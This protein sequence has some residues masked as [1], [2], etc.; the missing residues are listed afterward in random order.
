M[1]EK[2]VLICGS[3][4]SGMTLA[5]W[6]TRYGYKPKIIEKAAGLRKGGYMIDFWG[7]GYDTAEKMDILEELEKA[8]YNIP[9]LLY[10]DEDDEKVGHL[11]IQKLRKRL[12]YRH[13]NLLRSDLERILHEQIKTDV[14]I[15]YNLTIENLNQ[16]KDDVEVIFS[17]GRKERFDF[18]V[19]ADGQHSKTRKLLFGPEDQFEKFMGYYISSYTID[20]FLNK[21]EL[22]Y[23][24]GV[25]GKQ[26]AI[27]STHSEN[28]A[29]LF[30]W[31][32]DPIDY[33]FRDEEEQKEMLRNAFESVNWHVPRL[34]EHIDEADDFYFDAVSQIKLEKWFEN[35]V[36]LLGDACQCVS[37]L[38]GEG[39][40]LGMAGAYILAGE[41]KSH[42]DHETAF[43]TYQEKMNPEILR[44]QEL[45]EGFA[46]SFVP[47]SKFG[48]W[49][50]NKFSRIITWPIISKF[51][52]KRFLSDE[53]ELENY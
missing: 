9:K 26:A 51:F 41:M 2:S 20:N 40:G 15:D 37:L 43:K 23:W 5:W 33:D 28:L 11:D 44:T 14:P 50:R 10:V 31:K 46:S 39:S 49:L 27:Y 12:D 6:L 52:I 42:D 24:Y 1:K 13:F 34:L 53:L 7:V 29:T 25:P 30:T 4:I 17:D 21:D 36:V 3:G 45:G 22:F 32:S 16:S 18:V 38:A 8:H 47:D 19:G 48:I 35:R